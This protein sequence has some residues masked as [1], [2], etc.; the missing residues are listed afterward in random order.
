MDSN[1]YVTVSGTHDKIDVSRKVFVKLVGTLKIIF[2]FQTIRLVNT[3]AKAKR[4]R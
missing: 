1:T 3:R 4:T 2:I